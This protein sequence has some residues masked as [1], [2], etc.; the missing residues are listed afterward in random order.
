MEKYSIGIDFGTE[1]GRV[2]II[3]VN[4]GAIKACSVIPYTHGVIT[5][6]LPDEEKTEIP[7]DFALQH[8]GDYLNILYQGIPEAIKNADVSRQQIIGIGVDF[9][10]STMVVTDHNLEPL[11]FQSNYRSNPHAWAKLWK[12][13]GAE[14]EAKKIYNKAIQE[15]QDWLGR[16]GFHISTE[17][18][19]PKCLEILNEDREIYHAADLFL[20]AGDWIVAQLTGHIV[21][22]NCSLG[23]KALWSERSGF[24]EG[25]LSSVHPE[26][27]QMIHAK[28]RG[29]IGG[30]GGRA[31]GLTKEMAETLG[32]PVGLSVGVS[33]IDAHSAILGV[34]ASLPHQLTMVMGTSTCHMMLSEQEI[35][36]PGISGV[37]KDAVIPGL[38]TYEAGQ[39]AVGD[40]FGWYAKQVPYSFAKKAM[41]SQQSVFDLLESKASQKRPGESGLIALDW[42]N[43]N[44]S[45]LSDSNLTGLLIGL[46]LETEP[47]DIYRAYLEATAFGARII[48]ENYDENGLPIEDVFAC[49]GLPQKNKCLMQ[50]YADVLNRDIH[51]SS[52]EY[53]PA[54]G[55]A[56]LGAVAAGKNSGGFEN[57]KDA[58]QSMKQSFLTTYHPVKE[59]V[60]VYEQLFRIYK[61]LHNE[62]GYNRRMNKLKSISSNISLRGGIR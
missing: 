51:V 40:L 25:F 44:R 8:P 31:G 36:V 32:L 2:A 52:A 55:A 20:E 6:T 1:S 50:I 62:H 34:G 29:K 4:S 33:I 28:L 60:K 42:H 59:N 17:W 43:G 3:Q 23:F 26:L 11:C 12:H 13:H 41:K 9:T 53:A 54:I 27:A 57:I 45:I 7:N 24:P 15:N 18:F 30:I 35:Q 21:R 47:E 58:I 39:S 38:Y 14:T 10:S 5:K 61:Q 56:I 46:T 48:V 22:S 37:V 49:G 16:Y 19:L